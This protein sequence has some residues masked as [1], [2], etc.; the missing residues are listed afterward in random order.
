V[1]DDRAERAFVPRAQEVRVARRD[2]GAVDVRVTHEAENLRFDGFQSAGSNPR[3]MEPARHMQQV[4]MRALG[5]RGQSIHHVATVKRRD[6]E[7]FAV[8]RDEKRRV[9]DA[10]GHMPEQRHLLRRRPEQ[11]LLDDERTVVE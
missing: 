7:G 8:E 5:R 6:I 9:L 11:K 1:V 3:A 10:S 2:V 4:E